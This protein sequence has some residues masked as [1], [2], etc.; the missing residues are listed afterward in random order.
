VIAVDEAPVITKIDLHGD[1]KV[2]EKDIRAKIPF[3]AGDRMLEHRLHQAA[4][5]IESLYE[6]KGYYLAVVKIEPA[7]AGADSTAIDVRIDEGRKVA[8]RAI[9]FRGNRAY[10]G[11]RLRDAMETDEKGFWFWQQGEFDETKWRADLSQRLPA[12]YGEHGYLDMQVSVRTSEDKYADADNPLSVMPGGTACRCAGESCV[13]R[14]VSGNAG[15]RPSP[16]LR[17]QN[18][19]IRENRNRKTAARNFSARR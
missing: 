17:N 15:D 5:D 1:D 14:R 11:D 9:R 4:A 3:H 19:D 8:I 10:S 7:R 13:F 18:A 16:F 2:K 12:F 6:E